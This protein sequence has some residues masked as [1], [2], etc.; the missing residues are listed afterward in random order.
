MLLDNPFQ[1]RWR[2]RMVPHAFRINDRNR[3]AQAD[4][5]TIRLGAINQWLRADEVQLLQPP[6]EEFPRL[7]PNLFRRALRFCLLG[8]KKNMA[9]VL[10]Q[11]QRLDHRLQLL[12]GIVHKLNLY[13]VYLSLPYYVYY[14]LTGNFQPETCKPS[15]AA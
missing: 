10:F 1:N 5:K 11:P 8:A 6:F 7:Q 14:P 13:G 4:T 3:P 2:T 15:K 9:P 12:I